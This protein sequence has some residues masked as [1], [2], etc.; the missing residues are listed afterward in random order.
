MLT[1]TCFKNTGLSCRFIKLVFNISCYNSTGSNDYYNVSPSPGIKSLSAYGAAH[2]TCSI[3]LI[4]FWETLRLS[5]TKHWQYIP[6]SHAYE[7]IF[8]LLHVLYHSVVKGG[9]GV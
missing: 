7:A 4:E 9:G 3:E 1:Q 5:P 8:N 6:I 2:R